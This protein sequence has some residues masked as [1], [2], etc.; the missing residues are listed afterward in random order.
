M[1]QSAVQPR[2]RTSVAVAGSKRRGA[3]VHKSTQATPSLLHDIIAYC[4]YLATNSSHT[5]SHFV[6]RKQSQPKKNFLF[7]CSGGGA[8]ALMS[9]HA[10][11]K[12]S[13]RER[14]VAKLPSEE[15]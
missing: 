1:I 15:A 9:K 13:D 2:R 10:V 6:V 4:G 14:V 5:N 8:R 3:P 12:M 11:R 7:T